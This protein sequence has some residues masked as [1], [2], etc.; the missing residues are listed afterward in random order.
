MWYVIQ[1]LSGQED[2][3]CE[4]INLHAAGRRSKDGR[5]VLKECFVP[6]Y[7]VERKFHGQYRTLTRN[8]FP[9]YVIAVTNRVDELND[10]LVRI[11]TFTRMLGSEKSFIPLDRSEKAFINAFTTEKHRTISLSKAV[12]EGDKVVVTEG[13]MINR[14]GWITEV[15]RRK[16]TARIEVS[17]F[18]R[19]INVE[20]GLAIVG[21]RSEKK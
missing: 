19:T 3:A 7:Q 5:L 11:P 21:R 13:P 15:N 6:R 10:R 18:G 2:K 20:I 9:G 14:E 1:V 8:L 16:G 12:Y 17:M 4:L